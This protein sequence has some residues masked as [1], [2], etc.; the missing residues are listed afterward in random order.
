LK[1]FSDVFSS[2]LGSDL[3][4]RCCWSGAA[5]LLHLH[6]QVLLLSPEEVQGLQEGTEGSRGPEECSDAWKCIQ[7]KG[8]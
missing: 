3:H 6:L 5:V 2:V 8:P 1:Y 7:G 4:Y